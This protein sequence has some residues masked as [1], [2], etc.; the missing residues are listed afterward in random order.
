MIEGSGFEFGAGSGPIPLT[1]GSGDPGDPKTC[2]SGGSG[3]GTPKK[4]WPVKGFCGRCLSEFRDWRYSRPC[5]YL[6]PALWTVSPLTFS[7]VLLSPPPFL[8]Q[9]VRGGGVWGPGPQTDNTCRKV[10]FALP[11]MSLIFLRMFLS[12]SLH[13][14]RDV[15][16]Y[17]DKVSEIRNIQ[18]TAKFVH[19]V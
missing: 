11:S 7:L 10:H 8:C 4:N 17:S 13:K 12:A 15:L 9:C 2:G 16:K 5:Q 3:S 6:D 14:W 1:S 18:N 19:T